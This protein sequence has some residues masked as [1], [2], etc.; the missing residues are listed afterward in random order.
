M[1]RFTWGMVKIS[2][3]GFCGSRKDARRV[4]LPAGIT[5]GIPHMI[6][7]LQRA[8]R[9]VGSAHHG[10][11]GWA[12]SVYRSRVGSVS[13]YILLLRSTYLPTV[14]RSLC[15][16]GLGSQRIVSLTRHAPQPRPVSDYSRTH[17]SSVR[18][19][20]TQLVAATTPQVALRRAPATVK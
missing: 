1:M 17:Q 12:Y 2:K 19:V 13:G 5:H 20:S 10:D 7:R 16:E 11:P 9:T 18:A 8:C 6:D 3:S 15:L 14:T 4:D